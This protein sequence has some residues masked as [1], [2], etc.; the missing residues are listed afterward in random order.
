MWIKYFLKSKSNRS[1]VIHWSL[2]TIFRCYWIMRMTMWKYA[3]SRI[4]VL[5]LI[6]DII[7]RSLWPRQLQCFITSHRQPSNCNWVWTAVF[8]ESL[9]AQH[10]ARSATRAGGHRNSDGTAVGTTDS[11]GSGWLCKVISLKGKCVRAV[12]ATGSVCCFTSAPS[13]LSRL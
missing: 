12:V 13:P 4:P 11:R 1:I 8:F 9:A 6:G 2:P 7:T 10:V 5:H 3:W